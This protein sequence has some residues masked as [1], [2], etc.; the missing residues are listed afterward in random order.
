MITW[1]LLVRLKFE[2]SIRKFNIVEA[3]TESREEKAPFVDSG[4]KVEASVEVQPNEETPKQEDEY[5]Q[6]SEE[7]PKQE[8]EYVQPNEI[9][10]EQNE[11]NVGAFPVEAQPSEE[12]PKQEEE[13]VQPSEEI[14][15]NE[16]VQEQ[17]EENVEAFPIEAQPNEEVPKQEEKEEIPPAV[18]LASEEQTTEE[19][20][21]ND[22]SG[23]SPNSSV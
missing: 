11:E 8:E 4:E 19:D 18:A 23:E 7:T 2:R 20:V 12:V 16:I 10:Q 15:P 21:E 3:F 13:Y 14:Q 17:D 6:S 5:V 9:V 22:Q 1:I